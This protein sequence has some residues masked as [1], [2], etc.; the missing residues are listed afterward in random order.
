MGKEISKLCVVSSITDSNFILTSST[1]M[2]SE[3]PTGPA[4]CFNLDSGDFGFDS[5][6]GGIGNSPAWQ[7]PSVSSHVNIPI[8]SSYE[9]DSLF[10]CLFQKLVSKGEHFHCL[11]LMTLLGA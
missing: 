6:W 1:L 10:T 8:P 9:S 3:P 5:L 2:V 4:L 11:Q 7:T